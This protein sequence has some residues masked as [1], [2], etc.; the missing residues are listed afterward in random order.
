MTTPAALAALM[1]GDM[2]N[3]LVAS[4]HGGIEAQE[5]AG[6]QSFVAGETLPKE[7]PREDLEALGFVFGT[8]DDDLFINVI[9]PQGWHKKATDHPMHSDLIDDKGRIRG[10]IF[11]KAAFYD[12]SAHMSLSRRFSVQKNY[13]IEQ[14]Q[15][16]V[17]DCGKVAFETEII[18]CVRGTDEYW[19]TGDKLEAESRQW[20]SANYPEW[21]SASDYWD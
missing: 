3:F 11:Y 15:Y 9:M 21:E 8:D 20:L 6:Q 12:R 17:K 2:E 19:D 18:D 14:I 10:G 13:D 7:C 1:N 5:A 4:T 16:Q